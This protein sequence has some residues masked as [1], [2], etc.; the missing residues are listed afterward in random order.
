MKIEANVLLIRSRLN[1]KTRDYRARIM[2]LA[3]QYSVRLRIFNTF[4][5]SELEL[6]IKLD[7]S[8]KFQD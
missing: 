5:K 2:T 4:S 6:D 3:E 8:S 7:L 1:R